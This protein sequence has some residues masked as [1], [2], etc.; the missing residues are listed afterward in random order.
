MDGFTHIRIC[1]PFAAAVVQ[2]PHG[3]EKKDR[4]QAD[5]DNRP[6]NIHAIN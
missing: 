1:P 5:K 4:G 3:Q 2:C 6:I